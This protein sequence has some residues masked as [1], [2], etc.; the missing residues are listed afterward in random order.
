MFYHLIDIAVVNSY[1]L[2]LDHKA[3]FPDNEDLRRPAGYSQRE[4][5]EEI[6]RQ[7]CGFAEYGDPPVYSAGPTAEPCLFETQHMPVY[8]D[9]KRN[10]V[11]CYK[12]GRGQRKVYSHC[13][14]PQCEGKHMHI[15]K[16]LNC[17]QEFHSKEYH[18][19]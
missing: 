13:S 9:V 12:Q 10:C 7:I 5:R 4:F 16:E 6:V 14:A 18:G 19:L 15:T 17:F 8:S 11:V 2:F 1:I 3:R